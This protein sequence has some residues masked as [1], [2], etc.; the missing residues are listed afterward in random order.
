[1]S[2]ENNSARSNFASR[3]LNK[4]IQDRKTGE[5]KKPEL[6]TAE[7]QKYAVQAAETKEP[8]GSAQG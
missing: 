6:T 3:L 7:A 2:S 8:V 4:A 5:I 1:M